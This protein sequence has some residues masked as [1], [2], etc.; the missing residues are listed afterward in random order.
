[1]FPE[2]NIIT[3]GDQLADGYE[4][5]RQSLC[6]GSLKKLHGRET[7]HDDIARNEVGKN[8]SFLVQRLPVALVICR[9]QGNLRGVKKVVRKK[10]ASEIVKI[11]DSL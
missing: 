1:M 5:F 10:V 2:R 6:F 8:H 4:P 9:L 3:S 7:T 11:G